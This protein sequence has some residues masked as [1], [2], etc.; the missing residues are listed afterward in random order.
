MQTANILLALG[1]DAGNTVPKRNV[2]VGEIAVLRAIHGEE[3]VTDIEPTGTVQRTSRAE[4]QRLFQLYPAR[5][6]ADNLIVNLLYPGAAARVFE[7]LDELELNESFFKPTARVAPGTPAEPNVDEEEK[8]LEDMTIAQLKAY[9][10]AHQIDLAGATK[11]AEIIEEIENAEA[12]KTPVHFTEAS[13]G[14]GEMN[15]GNLFS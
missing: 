11:K 3:S 9:A 15:D 10:N 1:G 6:N 14:V 7:T 2:T 5:D 13:D 4:R 12:M 8:S